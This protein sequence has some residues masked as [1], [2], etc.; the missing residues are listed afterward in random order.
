MLKNT[1]MMNTYERKKESLEMNNPE[2]KMQSNNK[3]IKVENKDRGNGAKSWKAFC[4]K[5]QFQ[6]ENVSYITFVTY[7][8]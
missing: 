7:I 2:R 4:F 3:S 8:S 1:K 6:G 5:Y